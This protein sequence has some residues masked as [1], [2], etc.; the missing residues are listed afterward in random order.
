[1]YTLPFSIAFD[2]PLFSFGLISLF[3][4][5]FTSPV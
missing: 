1:M 4:L 3:S 5:I 2:L